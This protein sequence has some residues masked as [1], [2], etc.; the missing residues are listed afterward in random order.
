M[1]AERIVSGAA[2]YSSQV[3]RVKHC[4]AH[5]RAAHAWLWTAGA[6][7]HLPPAAGCLPPPC[8]TG[9]PPCARGW[10]TACGSGTDTQPLQ[11]EGQTG[12]A[13]AGQGERAAGGGQRP[14]GKQTACSC[15][16]RVCTSSTCARPPWLPSALAPAPAKRPRP[17]QAAPPPP[18]GP[19]TAPVPAP[20]PQSSCRT[21][22]STWQ[23]GTARPPARGLRGDG[24]GRAG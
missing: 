20:H 13:G 14:S 6:C 23:S 4:S 18:S 11:R 24:G 3:T 2:C 22:S 5:A 8:P 12:Q 21:Q 16:C 19:A 1:D 9:W 10:W 7:R 17:R 15:G